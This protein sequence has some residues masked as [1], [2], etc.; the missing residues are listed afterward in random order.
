VDVPSCSLDADINGTA[1]SFAN[2]AEGIGALAAFRQPHGTELVVM[3]ATGG[4]EARLHCFSS[5]DIGA[6]EAVPFQDIGF[7]GRFLVH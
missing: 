2:I 4:Y 6:A 1:D 3:E 7:L 5:L